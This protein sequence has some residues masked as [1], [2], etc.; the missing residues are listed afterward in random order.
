M[1]NEEGSKREKEGAVSLQSRL[2]GTPELCH[3]DKSAGQ[4]LAL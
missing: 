4:V 2:G 3:S 1:T